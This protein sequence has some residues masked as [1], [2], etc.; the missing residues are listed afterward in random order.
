MAA[1]Q[2]SPGGTFGQVVGSQSGQ[3]GMSNK[4]TA[5]AS[6]TGG[7][8]TE[9][10]KESPGGTMHNV[11][12]VHTGGGSGSSALQQGGTSEGETGKTPYSQGTGHT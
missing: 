11:S 1:N 7:T 3:E 5:S 2:E 10:N 8:S 12:D 4:A 9:G 6:T